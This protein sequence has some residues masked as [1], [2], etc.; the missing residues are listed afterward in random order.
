MFSWINKL[1]DIPDHPMVNLAAARKLLTEL[2]KDNPL[3]ALEELASWL[4]TVKDTPS[5]RPE[6][7][8]S[9]VMLLDETAQPYHAELLRDYLGAPHLQDFHG[10]YLWQGI[11]NFMKA[12]VEAY[13]LC[14]QECPPP[15]HLSEQLRESL[16]VLHVR[17]IRSIGEQMKLELMRYIEVEQSAWAGLCGAYRLAEALQLSESMVHAYP[18]NVIHT[19]PQ[20]ELLRA[21]A[22]YVSSPGTLAPNQIEVASRIAARMVSYFDMKDAPAADCPYVIDLAAAAPPRHVPAQPLPGP[23]MRFFGMQRAV[24][25]LQDITQQNE[26]GLL[27]EENRFGNE[28]SPDG[29]L[30]V[31]KHLQVYWSLDL[32]YRHLERRNIQVDIEV[33]HSYKTISSLVK[34]I[35]PGNIENL[36]EKDA[37]MMKEKSS[38]NLQEEKIDYTT[39]TWAVLDAST[40]GIGGIMP[41]SAAGW[42]KVGA[43]CALKPRESNQWW[44]GMIRRIHTDTQGKVHVGIEILAKKPLA[45]WMRILGKGT[46]KVSNWETSSGSFSYDYLHVILLPDAHNSY[47]NAT[48]LVESGSF[49]SGQICEMM[50][51]E[52]SRNIRMDKLLAEGDDY[53]QASFQW[54]DS[55]HGKG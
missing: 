4:T 46:E 12:Q 50:M 40:G 10:M 30:T 36:P 47:L 34:H 2:P 23:A 33:V 17:L 48:M 20:R 19:S 8:L 24:P 29:K 7:R 6:L 32:P 53:E 13:A 16:P 44:V 1:D 49:A 14:A 3:K 28:F 45:V 26:R 51:G 27:H 11:H 18:G 25:K 21:L 35:E 55:T 5:F 15:E 39:E 42:G 41:R 22:L 43:L 9:I 31:L 38:I 54:L 37:A 52:K